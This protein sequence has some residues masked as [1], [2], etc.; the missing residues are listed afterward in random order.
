MSALGTCAGA[1]LA[2]ANAKIT[3]RPYAR[4]IC[5]SSSISWLLRHHG[6]DAARDAAG[7]EDIVPDDVG[8]LVDGAREVRRQHRRTGPAVERQSEQR[9]RV[10][11]IAGDGEDD[12][13]GVALTVAVGVPNLH[14]L[15]RGQSG[16]IDA[17]LV[18]NEPAGRRQAE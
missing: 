8:R 3:P 16:E 5:I 2:E 17:A 6:L 11:R 7:I 9:A 4:K 18:R 10:E 12:G 13:R 14:E 15:E 1:W